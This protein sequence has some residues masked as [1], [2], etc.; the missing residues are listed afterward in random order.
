MAESRTQCCTDQEYYDIVLVGKT[1]Q[2]K[3]C[4]GNKLL[5]LGLKP[6]TEGTAR[7]HITRFTSSRFRGLLQDGAKHFLASASES[8]QL[9]NPE[10]FLSTTKNCALLSNDESKIRVLDVPGFADSETLGPEYG[11]NAPT[12]FDSNLQIFRL[13]VRVHMEMKL[14]VKRLVY[15]LPVRG[16]LEKADR[17]VQDEFRV[18]AH[19]FGNQVFDNM[20]IVA[21]QFR[22]DKCQKLG[23]DD[24]DRSMTKLALGI[25]L[26]KA[27]AKEGDGCPPIVFIGLKD[28]GERIFKSIKDAEV[29]NDGILSLKF[30][31]GVCS[32]CSVEYHIIGPNDEKF[33]KYP[34]TTEHSE[35]VVLR[36]TNCHPMFQWKYSM[37]QKIF[38]G[39]AHVALL[40]GPLAYERIT[41]RHTWPGFNNSDEECIKCKNSPGSAGCLKVN[42]KY[43]CKI[44]PKGNDVILS[45]HHDSK[46]ITD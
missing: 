43:K 16:P 7:A 23:F 31:D 27:V 40:G 38:G 17:V 14:K 42:T 6:E 3:S 45:V 9:L 29:L 21:T 30:R 8:G 33:C 36:D 12:V 1:G 22:R 5:G 25:V 35:E 41:Q 10:Q 4:T 11:E 32:K 24:E 2:G 44:K 34:S 37:M 15:F 26:K 18:M 13:L 46:I 39:L 19:F 28:E 20:V